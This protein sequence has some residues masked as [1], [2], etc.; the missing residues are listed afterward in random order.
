MR[1]LLFIISV[2]SL[3]FVPIQKAQ[4]VEPRM[5]ALLSMAA[6]GTIGGALL[7]T[8]SLAFGSSGRAVAKGAS[9]GLYTGL[10]FGSYVVISH[11]Y[12][13]HKATNPEPSKNYYPDTS[14]S[15]YEDDQGGG[16]WFDWGAAPAEDYPPSERWNPYSEL[17]DLKSLN[18]NK[19]KN[20]SPKKKAFER[21]YMV[22]V[23]YY[24]F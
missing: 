15:P 12:R 18:T 3:T 11:A 16:G 23:F 8:A 17:R 4:A 24:Q 20:L 10:L 2:M 7:G 14:E 6:Y 9:L 13:N 1:K 22:P 19:M 5:R 21:V